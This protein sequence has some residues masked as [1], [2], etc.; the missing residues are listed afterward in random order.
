MVTLTGDDVAIINDQV[1]TQVADGDWAVI[2]FPNDLVNVK[3]GKNG[4]TVYALNTS[5]LTANAT[6]RVP[7]G[8]TLDKFLNNLLVTMKSNFASFN[9]ITGT[10]TKQVGDGA[11]NITAKQ[12]DLSGGVFKKQAGAKANAEG[13][14][15]QGVMVYELVFANAAASIA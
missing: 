13:D 4:V 5:G 6:F 2:D 11:G 12:Y 7:V 10:F 14:A 15:A 9:L 1:F 8:G 3:Q